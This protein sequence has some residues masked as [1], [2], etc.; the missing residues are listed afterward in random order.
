MVSGKV[1]LGSTVRALDV[2]GRAL[3][4]VTTVAKTNVTTVGRMVATNAL[5]CVANQ[6]KDGNNGSYIIFSHNISDF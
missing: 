3:T 5:L 6:L 1:R 2:T 4:L